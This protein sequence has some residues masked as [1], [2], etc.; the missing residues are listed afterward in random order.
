[1]PA[2]ARA[3]RRRSVMPGNVPIQGMNLSPV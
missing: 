2:A 3:E 1:V